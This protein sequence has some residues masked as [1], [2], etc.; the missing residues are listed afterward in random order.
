MRK[1]RAQNPLSNLSYTIIAK[2]KEIS[3]NPFSFNIKIHEAL[4]WIDVKATIITVREF[5]L[6]K[7]M[8]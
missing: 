3:L 2:P 6:V 5:N 1:F 7:I 8:Y 4:Y